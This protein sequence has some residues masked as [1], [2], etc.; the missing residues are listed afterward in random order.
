[1]DIMSD[2]L[3]NTK[4]GRSTHQCG[5]LSYLPY[6]ITRRL[7]SIGQGSISTCQHTTVGSGRG[8]IFYIRRD[9][10]VQLSLSRA[11]TI[12]LSGKCKDQ[13]LDHI[14]LT[15]RHKW[16]HH[17]TAQGLRSIGGYN[18]LRKCIRYLVVYRTLCIVSTC[19]TTFVRRL[20]CTYGKKARETRMH[21]S[22][23][24]TSNMQRHINWHE[25]P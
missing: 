5:V 15:V 16:M 23:K 13:V 2:K 12:L 3:R 11:E 21:I 4:N 20:Q 14:L 18:V 7:V 17:R 1:M 10:C 19:S 25:S 8:V 6:R 9:N 24:Y 22:E